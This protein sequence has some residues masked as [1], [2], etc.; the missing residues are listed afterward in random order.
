MA[1]IIPVV[2]RTI[3]GANSIVSASW[4]PMS[5]GDTGIQVALTDFADRAIQISGTFGGAT[6]TI[7]GSN[8]GT[9]WN[10]MR[11][12]ASVAMTFTAADIKQM[13]EMAL[14]V[15]PIVTGGAGV[16]ITVVMAGRQLIPLAWS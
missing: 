12:P 5:T 2:N 6:V 13:L 9:N 10:T 14:Y 3:Q 1:N 15:R 11:D 8:D 7:Q 16:S 4:G